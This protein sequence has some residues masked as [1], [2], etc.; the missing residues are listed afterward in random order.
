LI[1][2]FRALADAF[3]RAITTVVVVALDGTKL[4]SDE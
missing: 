2:F 3:F 4:F 1:S